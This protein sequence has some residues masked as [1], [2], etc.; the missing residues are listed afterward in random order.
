MVA[1]AVREIIERHPDSEFTMFTSRDG[2][3]LFHNFDP[4]IRNFVLNGRTPLLKR[5]K[6]IYIFFKL[7]SYKFD[8][9]YC[10]DGDWRIRSL[11]RRSTG[12]LVDAKPR[13]YK[14]VVHAAIQTL[15][16]AGFSTGNLSDIKIPFI[17]A[18]KNKTEEINRYLLKLGVTGKDIL[19]GL[20]PSFSGL[21]RKKTRKYK[22]WS[23]A[24]WA[25]LADKLHQYGEQHDIP[26]K[27]A[28]YSL[29]RDRSLAQ[30]ISTLSSHPPILLTPEP[31]LELFKA[32][33][34]R[35]DLYIGPDTG[36]THLAAG[37]GVKLITLFAITNPLDCGP[38]VHDIGSS[39][40]RAEDKG[41]REIYLDQ[42]TAD[43]VF[44]LA[45]K[46]LESLNE[47]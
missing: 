22:L 44:A 12:N 29:P 7:K 16:A 25:Q 28:I 40:I 39:V 34:S 30:E 36:A 17:R 2:Y 35:L 1:P 14:N 4:R 19:V 24:N 33:L 13:K 21:N 8:L 11:V 23:P 38:I 27:I 43:E 47:R 9:A 6:W 37:L 42:I 46:K 45:E 15:N 32:Y 10:L 3:A 20:N 31:D 26:I 5:L 41:N 18:N